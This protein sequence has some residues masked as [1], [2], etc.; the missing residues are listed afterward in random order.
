MVGHFNFAW[1]D[2]TTFEPYE[3]E[4]EANLALYKSFGKNE[5]RCTLSS[6]ISLSTTTWLLNLVGR[7]RCV[8]TSSRPQERAVCA[9]F[10]A[11]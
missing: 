11:T 1:Q 2:A 8:Q 9:G 4:S 3:H 6:F 10:C 5:V 7:S